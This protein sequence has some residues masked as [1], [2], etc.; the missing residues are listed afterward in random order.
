MGRWSPPALILLL[1]GSIAAGVQ[2]AIPSPGVS[3]AIV[4]YAVG[5]LV[6][7]YCQWCW[8][9]DDDVVAPQEKPPKP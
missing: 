1:E 2:I 8:E 3:T 7:L 5:L 6:A 4:Y 9:S